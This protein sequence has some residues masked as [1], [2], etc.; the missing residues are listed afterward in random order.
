MMSG[1]DDLFMTVEVTV[2]YKVNEQRPEQRLTNLIRL[3]WGDFSF[4]SRDAAF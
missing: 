2:F 1:A 4:A 3:P